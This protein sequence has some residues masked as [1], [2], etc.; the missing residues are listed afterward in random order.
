LCIWRWQPALTR[1]TPFSPK[2]ADAHMRCEPAITDPM[3]GDF[4]DP[5]RPKKTIL[6]VDDNEQ[7]LSVRKFMLETRG[8][9]VLTAASSQQALELFREGGIDLVLS[10]L[11]MP[12]MDG[13]ELV[14]RMKELAPEV[15]AILIS[16]S[17]KA[18][19]RAN[20]ADAFLP[21]GACSPVEMLE[22]IRMMVARKRGPKKGHGL[23]P[24]IAQHEVGHVAEHEPETSDRLVV[25]A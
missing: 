25:G 20:R 5:M 22:R 1:L 24:L 4:Q 23:R 6:C 3:K 17:V 16:G 10:D 13:N 14:R 21:K 11:I 8:Y 12:Y 18:F 15:P 2:P 7:A 19:D 9:R